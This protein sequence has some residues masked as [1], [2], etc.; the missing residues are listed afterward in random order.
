MIT[1][2]LDSRLPKFDPASELIVIDLPFPDI[3]GIAKTIDPIAAIPKSI[4][5][6][7]VDKLLLMT[8][9]ELTLIGFTEVQAQTFIK[10]S[11]SVKTAISSNMSEANIL[12]VLGALLQSI[13]LSLSTVLARI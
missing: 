3:F 10:G 2:D 7:K 9:K 5:L 4:N 1:S 6:V 12:K 8:E 11:P 13:G